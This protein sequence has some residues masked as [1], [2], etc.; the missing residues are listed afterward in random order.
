VPLPHFQMGAG[1]RGLKI[2]TLLDIGPYSRVVQA[3]GARVR[4]QGSRSLPT[5]MVW[6]S[7][8]SWRESREGQVTREARIV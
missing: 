2:N 1:G 7:Q 6:D 4:S 5:K 3:R 8:T